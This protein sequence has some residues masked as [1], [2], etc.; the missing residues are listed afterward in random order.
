MLTLGLF[1]LTPSVLGAQCNATSNDLTVG[2]AI[3]VSHATNNVGWIFDF[4]VTTEAIYLSMYFG[5][6][7]KI[8]WNKT[9]AWAIKF[10]ND[11]G[12]FGK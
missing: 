7:M 5:E 1:L 10:P 4:Q 6:K 9:L 3:Q 12:N 11:T 2:S 8:Y